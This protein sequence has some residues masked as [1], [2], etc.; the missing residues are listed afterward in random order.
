MKQG[1]LKRMI[2]GCNTANGYISFAADN[3]KHLERVFMLLGAPGCGKSSIIA[4]VAQSLSERG[5][6]VELW[7]A[8]AEPGAAEGVIIP[9]LQAAVVDVGFMEY[10]HP[11][12]LG[13]VEEVY[14]LA[15]C[16]QTDKLRR[17]HREIKELSAAVKQNM[18][19]EAGLLTVY[20][21]NR[22]KLYA[23]PGVRLSEEEID[24]IA[25]CLA[26]KIFAE[27]FRL[28]RRFFAAVYTAD[29]WLSYAQEVSAGCRRFLLCGNAAP[30]LERIAALSA[31][32]GFDID[33]YYNALCLDT[34]QMLILPQLSVAVLAA[35]LPGLEPLYTDELVDDKT[36]FSGR[37]E[38]MAPEDDQEMQ[39]LLN[40]QLLKAEKDLA[41]LAAYYTAATDFARVDAICSDILAKLWQ[42]AAERGY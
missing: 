14:N 27:N 11:Q 2:V 36:M 31:A 4:R 23:A 20:S 30:V 8:A 35:D 28:V 42:M 10:L 29:G 41:D 25:A 34:L 13:V 3:I 6:D 7:Q 26:E 33:L 21:Q 5:L 37:A 24:E 12:N 1:R 18:L 38:D 16:W 22:P 40:E 32:R 9:E 17:Y 39:Q 15:E 19:T